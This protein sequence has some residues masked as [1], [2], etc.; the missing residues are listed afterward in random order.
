MAVAHHLKDAELRQA[1]QEIAR[2]I[3]H[4]LV[5]LDPVDCPAR[6]LSRL[7]WSID[8]GSF[9]RSPEVL[10]RFLEERYALEQAEVFTV[11]HSYFVCV[12][13]PRAT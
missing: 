8:R 3:R 4:K 9:P 5:F 6:P 13:K 1:L 2:V 11:L 10:R 7:L 12:A